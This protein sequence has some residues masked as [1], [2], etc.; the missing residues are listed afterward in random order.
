MDEN[1]EYDRI[2]PARAGFTPTCRTRPC[3]PGDHPRSRGVYRICPAPT[4]Q[5][6]GSS[7]L[8]RGLPVR[9]SRARRRARIIPARAGFTRQRTIQSR[10]R[11]DHPRSRGVYSRA[12]RAPS[13]WPGSSPLAR[14]LLH[15]AIKFGRRARIIPARAGFTKT[16]LR[17][18]TR[19]G[20]HPRSRGVYRDAGAMPGERLGSSPLARGLLDHDVDVVPAVR[21]IPARAGFTKVRAAV[22]DVIEDH[23]RSRG[24]Y[25][26]PRNKTAEDITDHP[27][28]RG[29]Y[30][31]AARA[32]VRSPGSSPLARGLPPPMAPRAPASWI[33]PARAGFTPRPPTGA[34]GRGDHPRSRGVYQ[35]RRAVYPCHP[36]SSPLARG[37]QTRGG[38]GPGVGGIIPARA[39]FTRFPAA[40][41][42]TLKDH[43]R[44][45]GVYATGWPI[46]DGQEGS[47]P[48]ARGLR[49]PYSAAQIARMDHPRS[50]GVYPG[51]AAGR[52]DPL[53]SSPLAR[54]LQPHESNIKAV[55]RII[56]AR[57]GFTTCDSR[58]ASLKQDHP[59]SRGVY[60]IPWGLVA[61]R[62][63]SSPLA[64]G[65]PADAVGVWAGTGIIPA[66]AGFTRPALRRGLDGQDHPRSRGVYPN[67]IRA[68][69]RVRGSSPLARG[70]P[71]PAPLGGSTGSDHPRSR[72]V[73]STASPT[74]T[75]SPGSSPLA[76]GL[77]PTPPRRRPRRWI[78]PARAGFT[79]RRPSPMARSRDHPRSRG[80]YRRVSGEET[81][82][83][84]SSPLARG[85][86]R[87][88]RGRARPRG[89]I[90]AR[91]GFTS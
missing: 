47:S 84:G 17:R 26:W 59:R 29:V 40:E 23:P 34:R 66:R 20:D 5:S 16:D 70:L 30:H 11:Q 90:P 33:I 28:S 49:I 44:S 15:E 36:G 76:R 62:S 82:P 71:S 9:E 73:Y 37:L 14:G 58:G 64:R 78:I 42:W 85:L 83:S 38:G 89:I 6:P 45:R 43:P 3:G 13:P 88:L 75:C 19:P 54:G 72:G 51:A 24:V 35:D 55:T 1:K 21:I 57:A 7:P 22:S 53:G 74:L 50:R 80:V 61:A 56:P 25:N 63:G 27:R 81:T 60:V 65:L 68:V 46:E 4:G 91:A 18:N 12:L 87:L 86:P 32:R 77:R 41:E 2:I 52:G 10:R 8:A 39:G 79:A 69:T 67:W 31:R 48:L